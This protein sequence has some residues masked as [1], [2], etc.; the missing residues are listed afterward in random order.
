VLITPVLLTCSDGDLI[1]R[2][3]VHS[4]ITLLHTF[5]PASHS[6]LYLDPLLAATRTY[7]QAEGARL[8]TELD[9]SA[10]LSQVERRLSQE[11]ERAQLYLGL[12]LGDSLERVVLEEMAA[13]HVEAIVEK[14]LSAMINEERRNDLTS[15]YSLL[16]Q[17]A[18]VTPLRAAFLEH[19]KVSHGFE[20]LVPI[21]VSLADLLRDRRVL[22]WRLYS[23][24]HPTIKWSTA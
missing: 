14:D 18:S 6:A 23:T 7:Y 16:N 1:P 5:S 12:Q 17:V 9:S 3:L 20:S 10:Y 21:Q 4:V 19:I 24:L 13:T 11:K 2:P 15:V 8:A 22:V